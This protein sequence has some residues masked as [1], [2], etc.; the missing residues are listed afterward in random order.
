MGNSTV[1]YNATGAQAATLTAGGL[2]ARNLRD[3]AVPG[4]GFKFKAGDVVAGAINAAA[5]AALAWDAEA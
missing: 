3:G 1:A 4:D 5:A 2:W